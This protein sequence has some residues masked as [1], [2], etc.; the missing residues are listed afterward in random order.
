MLML[1]CRSIRFGFML[2]ASLILAASAAARLILPLNEGWRFALQ[3]GAGEFSAPTF[4][5]GPWT[6]VNLPHTWNATDGE[7]GGKYVRSDGWYRKTFTTDPN[8]TGLRVFIEFGGA[9]RVAEV[10]LNGTRI[11]E[12]RGGYGRFRFDLTDHLQ[13]SGSNVLAV[14]VNNE[15][16]GI[17]PLGGDF[18]VWGGLHRQVQ[19]VI[20]PPAHI[21]LGDYA[22]AGVYLDTITLTRQRA[23][24]RVRT[25]LEGITPTLA[26][27][28]IRAIVRDARGEIVAEKTQ[29]VLPGSSSVDEIVRIGSPHWWNGRADPHLYHVTAELRAGGQLIDTVEQPL[30]LRTITVDSQRGLFLNGKHVDVHGVNRHHDRIDMGSAITPTEQRE[31]FLMIE[32][33][34]ATAVRLCHYEHDD[35]VYQL[36]DADGLLVW[37]ELAFV[38]APPQGDAASDNAVEQ[39][40]ELIRQNYNH[41]SIFCWSVGNETAAGADPLIARLATEAKKEDPYRFTTYASNHK[42]DDPRNFRTDLL[43]YN[44]YQGWYNGTYDDF[45]R[46]LDNWHTK[47]PT[48][49]LG[50]SEY[51]AGASV[52]QH[53]QNPP[54][55]PRTQ[56]RGPW[57]PEEWQNEFHEHAWLNIKQRPYLWGTFIWCMFDFGSDGRNEGD[58]PG[59]NDKGLVTYDRRTRKDAFYWYKANWTDTPLVYITSRRDTVRF[60]P[61]TTVK[62]YSNCDSVELLLNGQPAG[63]RTSADRRFIWSNVTLTPGPNRL[64]VIGTKAGKR[65]VDSCSWTLTTGTPYKPANDPAVPTKAPAVE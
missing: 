9:N 12:H 53:E 36:T 25:L 43:G 33:L 56:A 26:G 14:R 34:G 23:E 4:K 5:D 57:H 63:S 13:A 2:I 24:V 39:L 44:R 37:A 29:P 38:G 55:R 17:V 19:L 1:P 6:L 31:D 30:G 60:E 45:G 62:V 3:P 59:R 65:V 58:T 48:R 22:S 28:E 51:G 47:N 46:W 15:P 64:F 20:V 41:P 32:E 61:T 40:R 52:Y 42:E 10:W 50:L 11:G 7:D 21:A 8:W 35:I 18:T 27:A 16:N 49:P 54:A